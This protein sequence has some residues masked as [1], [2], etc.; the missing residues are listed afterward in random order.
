[1]SYHYLKIQVGDDQACDTTA[2]VARYVF[3]HVVNV[4]ECLH[5]IV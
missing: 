4:V 2:S 1:M 3:H 5:I